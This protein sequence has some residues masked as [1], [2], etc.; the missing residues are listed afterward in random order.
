MNK[1]NVFRNFPNNPI[2]PI[3]KKAKGIFLYTKSG[4]K[5][6]DLTAGS[7]SHAI[8]GYSHPKVIKAIQKQSKLFTHI[9]YKSWTDENLIKLSNILCSR[10]K[11]GLNRV[12]FAG[13]SGAEAC[14]ASLRMSY[15]THY[16]Q[17]RKEK[18]WVISRKQSYHGATGDAMSLSD[19]PNLEFFKKTLS[20]YRSQISMHHPLYLKNKNETL[21]DYAKRGARDLEKKIIQIG[22]KNVGAFVGETIMGGLVGDVPPAPNYWKYIR[23]ICDKYDVHLI[24]DE[25]YCG[26]G[27]SGKVFCCDWDGV[28]PDFIFIGKTLAAGYGALS[29]VIT[30]KSIEKIIKKYQGRLQHNTTYQGHSLSAAAAL[31]VQRIV[32]KDNFLLRVNKVGNFMRSYIN[33]ELDRHPFYREV[34]GRGL[35][36]SFEYFCKNRDEFSNKLSKII[37]NKHNIY[38]SIKFHRICFT[39]PLLITQSQAEYSLQKIIYEFKKLSKN[40]K[41]K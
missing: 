25:V 40:W 19:R 17:G 35:R 37:F 13:N 29:A 14:E 16:D 26:T 28:K 3:I 6:M 30:S 34:R 22:P 20:P 36:F 5:I 9:D 4:K 18:K 23:K 41:T 12:Y 39:P 24:L 2:P 7:N 10:A 11:H 15:Q 8:V 27:S 32:H 38:V 33:S 21:D 1:S 31:A